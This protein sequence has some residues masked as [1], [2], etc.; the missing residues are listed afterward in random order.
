MSD[1]LK[2]KGVDRALVVKEDAY[3]LDNDG[4][5]IVN[6]TEFL[7]GRHQ[8]YAVKGHLFYSYDDFYPIMSLSS[9]E[10]D[11]VVSSDLVLAVKRVRGAS[12]FVFIQGFCVDE[13]CLSRKELEEGV[14]SIDSSTGN[15]WVY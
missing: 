1:F 6:Y 12:V 7:I 5:Y 8:S 13:R 14:K 4:G 3:F 15:G 9:A 11:S 2:D 10:I